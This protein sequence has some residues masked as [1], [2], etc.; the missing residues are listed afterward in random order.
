MGTE[1]LHID[2]QVMKA[3]LFL[4]FVHSNFFLTKCYIILVDISVSPK[5]DGNTAKNDLVLPAEDS[6]FV[7]FAVN[8]NI[9]KWLYFEV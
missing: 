4:L 8:N 6:C 1:W 3:H 9:R 2:R 5:Q 7:F